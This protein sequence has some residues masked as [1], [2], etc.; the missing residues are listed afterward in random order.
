[1]GFTITTG[2]EV[3][4]K[5]FLIET[6]LNRVGLK[7]LSRCRLRIFLHLP[8]WIRTPC[9]RTIG[10]EKNRIQLWYTIVIS[11]SLRAVS[12][13]STQTWRRWSEAQ[14]CI[15]ETRETVMRHLLFIIM[16]LLFRRHQQVNGETDFL[17]FEAFTR[18]NSTNDDSPS[19][20]P[21]EKAIR[22]AA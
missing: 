2:K 12:M 22:K 1:V 14:G 13:H 19:F 11:S 4:N 17:G 3:G 18:P 5:R 21:A 15:K 9:C 10:L 6:R 20:S 16:G 8:A 7:Q